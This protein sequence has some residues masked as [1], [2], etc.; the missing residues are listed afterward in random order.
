MLGSTPA[1]VND[2][3]QA[4]PFTVRVFL[5]WKDGDYRAMPGGLTR[6]NPTGEDGIV[7]LQQGSI[8]K[9]TWVLSDGPI[10]DR[11]I[12]LD[13]AV[14]EGRSTT[15]TASRLA[16]NLYWFGRYLERT[17][18]L[19]RMLGKLD[20]LLRD[21]IA[22]LDP[23]VAADVAALLVAVQQGAAD[24]S[25]RVDE[26]AERARALAGDAELPGT[27][28]GDLT[29]LLAIIDQIKVLL[30]PEAWRIV[31]SLRETLGSADLVHA[32]DLREQLTALE[33]VSAES[34]PHDTAWRFLEIGRRIER[35]TQLSRLWRQLVTGLTI[36]NLSEF[37]VQTLLHFT[38]NLFSYRSVYHGVFQPIP[39]F[40]WIVGGVENPRSLRFQA[41]QL[42]A[43]LDALP[44]DLAPP[45]VSALRTTAFRLVS[46]I[47][48]ADAAAILGS[49]DSGTAFINDVS[50]LLH[51]LSERITLIYF[52]HAELT[53]PTGFHV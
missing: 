5:T 49:V 28:A 24:P 13:G 19:A 53:N 6:F 29:Q 4:V 40:E 9:D 43:H 48:L 33:S 50:D 37:R 22:V 39:V 35:A 25:R 52:A 7:S 47:R 32:T 8:T 46:A 15:I 17:S 51:D 31:R 21:E 45:A 44:N 16:D 42:S 10:E 38:D 18:H 1:F 20:P 27:L 2:K 12:V 23:E 36:E 3:I 34:L 41:E 14:A 30:P 11:P 26:L